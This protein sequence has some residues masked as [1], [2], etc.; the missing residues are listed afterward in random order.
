MNTFQDQLGSS[1]RPAS[2]PYE[3]DGVLN[4]TAM[5]AQA[6]MQQ[7]TEFQMWASQ[8]ATSLAKLKL[9]ATMAKNVN[10]QQ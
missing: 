5:A 3:R 7:A 9:F 8:Q 6:G 1:M 4:S 2:N 10:D